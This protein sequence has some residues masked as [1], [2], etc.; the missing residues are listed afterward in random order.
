[1]NIDAYIDH[2]IQRQKRISSEL[3]RFTYVNSVYLLFFI[4]MFVKHVMAPEV[5]CEFSLIILMVY[6]FVDVLRQR[7]FLLCGE[8]LNEHVRHLPD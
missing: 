2:R 7:K 1:M 6:H 4:T 5:Y 8:A 3:N